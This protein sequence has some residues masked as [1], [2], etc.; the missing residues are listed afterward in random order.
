MKSRFEAIYDCY[1][2]NNYLRMHGYAMWRKKEKRERKKMTIREELS[3][4]FPESYVI[5]RG[6]RVKMK[7]K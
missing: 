2:S 3:A 1:L 6:K 4:P 7:S 5:R